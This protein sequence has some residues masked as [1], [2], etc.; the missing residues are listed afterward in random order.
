MTADQP[1]PGDAIETADQVPAL[2]HGAIVQ[3]RHGQAY[4]VLEGAVFAAGNE[5]RLDVDDLDIGKPFTV[6][7]VPGV[8]ATPPAEDTRPDITGQAALLRRVANR[9]GD[10]AAS[11]DFLV[12]E[13]TDAGLAWF[14]RRLREYADEATT[15]LVVDDRVEVD[16]DGIGD[17]YRLAQQD[18]SHV[19]IYERMDASMGDVPALVAEVKRLA[20]L[21]AAAPTTT[22]PTDAQV[23]AALNAMHPKAAAPSLDY[24]GDKSANEM[25]AALTAAREAGR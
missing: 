23:L 5:K 18:A 21:L 10:E 14:I 3:G 8:P 22:E 19:V 9:L 4:L 2:P 25:R 11:L 24:W 7:F 17:R 15:G 6:L 13:V 16:L 1:R 20:G 12:N